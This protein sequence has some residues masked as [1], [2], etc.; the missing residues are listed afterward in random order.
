MGTTH[1]TG[2]NVRAGASHEQKGPASTG[3]LTISGIATD[4]TILAVFGHKVTATGT[5]TVATITEATLALSAVTISA[6]D[7]ITLAGTVAYSGYCF[8]VI[9]LDRD[10]S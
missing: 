7:T 10:A 4:D 8:T 5:N 1:F 6:A 3:N 2:L 9:Y